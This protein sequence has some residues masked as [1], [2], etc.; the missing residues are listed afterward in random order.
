MLY[1]IA[2]SRLCLADV[3]LGEEWGIPAA[4]I[5]EYSICTYKSTGFNIHRNISPGMNSTYKIHSGK[6]RI[7]PYLS[8]DVEGDVRI[9]MIFGI[10]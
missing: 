6:R 2:A 9:I 10:R 1:Y 4:W 7:V 5:P 8:I 3:R